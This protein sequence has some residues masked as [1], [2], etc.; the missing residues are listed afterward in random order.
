[1]KTNSAALLERTSGKFKVADESK[2]APLRTVKM[3]RRGAATRTPVYINKYPRE[4]V[5][6][7]SERPLPGPE[8]GSLSRCH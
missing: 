5:Q 8:P 7:H 4:N 6:S 3:Q 1:M 2:A